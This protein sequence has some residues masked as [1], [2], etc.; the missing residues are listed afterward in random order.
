[1]PQNKGNKRKTQRGSGNSSNP[2][3]KKRNPNSTTNS[4]V[5]HTAKK[6]MRIQTG[7]AANRS[8][9]TGK[10]EKCL[11]LH[12][13][14]FDDVILKLIHLIAGAMGFMVPEVYHPPH[15]GKKCSDWFPTQTL[16]NH[17]VF[18][19][20]PFNLTTNFGGWGIGSSL[21]AKIA[22][23][24]EFTRN[25]RNMWSSP[26]TDFED[27][28]FFGFPK[29]TTGQK[30]LE[31]DDFTYLWFHRQTAIYTALKSVSKFADSGQEEQEEI[32]WKYTNSRIIDSPTEEHS[33]D[34]F[35]RTLI[36]YCH[37]RKNAAI[38][39][40]DDYGRDFGYSSLSIMEKSN[41]VSRNQIDHFTKEGEIESKIGLREEMVPYD[42]AFNMR[43][44]KLMFKNGDCTLSADTRQL[45]SDGDAVEVGVLKKEEK[46][47]K[48]LQ[49][50]RND[51]V[52]K[53]F[54][55]LLYTIENCFDNTTLQ[56]W[57]YYYMT[58]E[59]CQI[60]LS[61]YSRKQSAVWCAPPVPEEIC[62][63]QSTGLVYYTRDLKWF[64]ASAYPTGLEHL[65][66]ETDIR[67]KEKKKAKK[68]ILNT[69]ANFLKKL[70]HSQKYHSEN[71][72]HATNYSSD[73]GHTSLFCQILESRC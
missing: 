44:T 8:I 66:Q 50:K 15:L 3:K 5:A 1:M 31:S 27:K 56:K 2:K 20:E 65:I 39:G 46:R 69:Q 71:G 48:N 36:Q 59:G 55:Y 38:S 67:K 7:G 37:E 57:G 61:M 70:E 47:F 10:Q 18:R 42:S 68:E 16:V 6:A 43:T 40:N 4:N 21:R 28:G 33:L 45:L 53:Y 29:R 24:T 51:Q 11:N 25:Y 17:G 60:S 34:Q 13:E 14:E 54:N 63:T 30:D 41:P 19:S 73:T 12:N 35:M 62:P 22:I 23:A 64:L 32:K 72:Y 49:S 52:E 26:E 58:H 9:E